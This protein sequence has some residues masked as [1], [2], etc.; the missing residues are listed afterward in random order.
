MN[1][2]GLVILRL[3]DPEKS[4]KFLRLTEKHFRRYKEEYKFIVDYYTKYNTVPSLDLFRAKFPSFFAEV[5][6]ADVEDE[7]LID[8]LEDARIHEV[9]RS[10][11]DS[12][13]NYLN[14]AKPKKA[15]DKL[16]DIVNECRLNFVSSFVRSIRD[17]L[18]DLVEDY[19][20]TKLGDLGADFIINELNYAIGGVRRGEVFILASRPGV[21]KTWFLLL[22][23][24]NLWTFGHKVLFISPEMSSLGLARR[25]ISIHTGLNPTRIRKGHLSAEEESKLYNAIND[26]TDDRFHI[27]ADAG[28][29]TFSDVE[30]AL[31][32]VKPSVV[33]IDGAYLIKPSWYVNGE[34]WVIA[35]T[36]ADWLSRV[37]KS[38]DVPLIASTQ[39]H[40][41]TN[42]EMDEVGLEDLAYS[43]AF[44]Q[45]ADFVA[46]FYSVPFTEVGKTKYRWIEIIRNKWEDKFKYYRFK[47]LKAR[48]G[49]FDVDIFIGM[50]FNNILFFDIGRIDG[51]SR[52]F[53]LLRF[54]TRDKTSE[55]ER[56]LQ[57]LME[58]IDFGKPIQSQDEYPF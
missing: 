55:M 16:V 39:L 5:R 52:T 13:V 14:L 54:G 46:Y 2:E 33:Y 53:S 57:N 43:D 27:M 4:T 22:N 28:S 36:V 6:E 29:F 26:F 40:R 21:G 25:F 23:A 15:Y 41:L 56:I 1:V 11:L 24:Y 3:L 12:V 10:N 31:A 47:L 35:K 48:E 37:A 20:R 49:R 9:I 19:N 32:D 45:N 42:K 38:Y 44:S 50:D 17:T 34:Y 51:T 18:T 30:S 58:T 8:Y 7:Y